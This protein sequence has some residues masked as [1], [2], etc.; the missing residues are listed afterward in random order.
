VT[1]TPTSQSSSTRERTGYW[2]AYY[3]QQHSQARPLPS[4][5]ATFVAGELEGRQR[6]V[7]FGCGSGRDSIFFASYGHDVTGVDGSA[8][9]VE[10][11]R[12]LSEALGVQATFVNAM[13]DDESLARRLGSGSGPLA[14]YARFFVHAIT[15]EEEETF[16]D[17]V[18]EVTSPGDL[19]AVEYRTVRDQSGVKVTGAHFRRFVTPA[20][21]QAR[22]LGRGFEVAYAVEGFG[23]AKYRQDDAYVAREIFTR[24]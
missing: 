4:Q 2:D 6:V 3:G 16:L 15:D 12:A 14:V 1:L 17:L 23:F 5:F 8:A 7:E 21:F 13:V 9:A 22:A 11:C 19:L 10:N 18:A 20:T 24:R